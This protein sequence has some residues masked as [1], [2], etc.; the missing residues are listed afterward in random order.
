LGELCILK[1]L[2]MLADCPRGSLVLIDELELA[3]HPTA[4]AELLKYLEQIA[5][6]KNLTVVVS[7]HSSTLIKQASRKQILFLQADDA[8]NVA[9]VNNCFP[10]FVL[11][12]LAYREEAA[13]DVVIYVED[14]AA[15]V[16][17][18]ELARRFIADQFRNASMLP[19]VNAIPVGGFANVLR[20]FVRQKP[21]LPSVTRAYAM[22]DADAEP[23]LDN[24]QVEDIVRIYRDERASISFLPFTPEVGLVHFLARDRAA[25]LTKLRQLFMMNTLTL[26]A[27]DLAG[28]PAAGA[29]NERDLCKALVNGVCALLAGQLPNSSET[30]V[31]NTRFRLLAEHVF[32]DDRPQ[33][34][35]VFGPVIRG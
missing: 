1:L 5:A 35:R 11:G 20:F 14:E 18:E 17:V 9:C 12:A 8:G 23:S 3:L 16:V 25:V 13:S 10:S 24:A 4:Q 31:R 6:A 21:L 2:K 7:T 30:D 15:R 28:A 19:S 22:L 26:R 34:M 32:A 27:I 33:V 29:A